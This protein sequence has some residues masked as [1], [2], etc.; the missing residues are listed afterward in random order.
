[1]GLIQ[2]VRHFLL[3][4]RYRNAAIVNSRD[5]LESALQRMPP[6]IVV[7]GNEA[8]RAYAATLVERDAEK[9]AALRAGAPTPAVG[10]PP[11]YMIVPTVGRIRDGYRSKRPEARKPIPLRNGL[12]SVVVAVIGIIAALVMEW[13][14]YPDEE[15]RMVRGPHRPGMRVSPSCFHR[16]THVVQMSSWR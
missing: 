5:E 14:I 4:L 9:L 1:M 10:D 15:P 16:A 6:R 3:W 8:L 11:V 13:L 2:F 7:E 12:D